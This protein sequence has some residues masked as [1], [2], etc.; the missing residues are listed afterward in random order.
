MAK[1]NTEAA[2]ITG[3]KM[4]KLW[5]AKKL[6]RKNLSNFEYAAFRSYKGY[7]EGKLKTKEQALEAMEI[8]FNT[9]NQMIP[10]V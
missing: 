9:I 1:F 6:V 5:Q 3:E 2:W 10:K 8:L 7:K 4:Y